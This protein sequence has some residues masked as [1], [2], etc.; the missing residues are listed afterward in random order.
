MARYDARLTRLERA[1]RPPARESQIYVTFPLT[2]CLEAAIE[3]AENEC[4]VPL[5]EINPFQLSGKT[6]ADLASA[7]LETGTE[8]SS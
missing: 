7:M 4:G 6:W 2:E 1:A 5:L 3:A 8:F